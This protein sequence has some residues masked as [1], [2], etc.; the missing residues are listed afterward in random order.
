MFNKNEKNKR[1]I[2]ESKLLEPDSEIIVEIASEPRLIGEYKATN[3]GSLDIDIELPSDLDEG[4]HT[5]FL[6]S[7]SYSGEPIELYDVIYF[8]KKS[9]QIY[10]YNS[11]YKDNSVSKNGNVV[12]SK[13]SAD[14]T[15]IDDSNNLV[16]S[17][18]L[19][20]PNGQVRGIQNENVIPL[21]LDRLEKVKNE[22][23]QPN[24]KIIIISIVII[25]VI[26]L[27]LLS[28]RKIKV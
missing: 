19:S 28:F 22:N 3:D 14:S 6:T 10:D 1:L 4:Y 17:I 16:E 7:K 2:L 15:F 13:N 25:L 8:S 20:D 24:A 12:Y 23:F 26:T 21:E 11:N 27:G 18:S 9:N 5:V